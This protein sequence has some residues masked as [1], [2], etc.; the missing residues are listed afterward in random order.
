MIDFLNQRWPDI[1]RC[2][3]LV[4]F[5]AL[6]NLQVGWFEA[7]NQRRGGWSGVSRCELSAPPQG[8][9]GVFLKRQENHKT[10]SWRHPIRGIPTC[11][12]E[13]QLI[14]HYKACGIPAL[15]PVYFA[16]RAGAGASGHT[17]DRG[18]DGLHFAGIAGSGL[19]AKWFPP[20][21]S[22]SAMSA[23]RC[24]PVEPDPCKQDS[25]Q[26]LLPKA[27][28]RPHKPRGRSRCMGHRS[29]KVPSPA[30][31]PLS[32]LCTLRDLDTLNRHAPEWGRGDCLRFLKSYLDIGRLT[33][34]A[35]WLWRRLA[36]RALAKSGARA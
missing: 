27:H 18:T 30:P 23:S 14:M 28:I 19:A 16:L 29:R 8:N 6:W 11:L 20:R 2:N 10:F 36:A 34:Y 17:G 21:E 32:L 24:R 9:C 5:D 3:G 4:D 26:L 33:P 35:K 7:P 22:S 12:H 1:L 15:E 31:F 25:A 13:I